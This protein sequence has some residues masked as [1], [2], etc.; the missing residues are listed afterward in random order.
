M[1]ISKTE[2]RALHVLAQGGA[3]RFDR[4]PNGKI[5]SVACISRDGHL[6]SDCTLALFQ[7]LKR[8][9][10]IKSI[11]GKPY[12]ITQAGLRCVR[13]QLDNR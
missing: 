6:L 8:R 2:Q 10:F 13:S 1:N 3:I 4:L 12:R 5:Q 7:R 9:G 11:K